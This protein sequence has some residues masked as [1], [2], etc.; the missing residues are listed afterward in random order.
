MV[1]PIPKP[2][3]R[4]EQKTTASDVSFEKTGVTEKICGY[5]AEK[6]IVKS[7]GTTSEVWA[8]DQLGNYMGVS[9][10]GNPMAGRQQEPP[11]WE[12]ALM[13][14]NFFPLRTVVLDKDGKEQMRMEVTSVEKQSLPASLFA[15][16]PEYS[17]FKMPNMGDMMKGMIPGR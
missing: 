3:A 12:K 1:R 7:K 16:G 8:T 13:G 14:K 11:P 15:P 5:T 10:G 9:G 2:E 4:P 17:E 6:Y